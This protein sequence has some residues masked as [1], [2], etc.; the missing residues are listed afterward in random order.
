MVSSDALRA[1]VGSGE[2]DLEASADAF[3]V[4]HQVVAARSR[5]GLTVVVDTLGLDPDTRDRYRE[6]GRAAGLPCVAVVLDT[7][8]ATC[9]ERNSRRDRPVPAKVLAQ[10]L[11]RMPRV[12]EDVAGEGWDVVLHVDGSDPG[13]GPAAAGTGGPGTSGPE[14]A[15]PATAPGAASA[16]HRGPRTARPGVRQGLPELV[17]QVSRFPWGQDPVG[18]LRTVALA[19]DEAGFSGLALM[20]HLVQVPQVDRAWEPIPEPWVTLGLLAGLDTSLRLGT[21]VS[22]MTFRPAGVLAKAAATLDVLSGGRAFVGVGA[23]WWEREHL[24]FGVPFPPSSTRLDLLEDGIETMRALWASGTRAYAGQRVSLPETTA[25]PRPVGPLPVVVGGGGERR[26]LRVAARLGDACNVSS[27]RATVRRKVEVLHRHCS[28]VGRDPAE[29]AVTVLDVPV[30][31]RDREDTWRRVERLRGRT[32]AAAYA[33]T[34][35][36]GEPASHVERY[37]Q[38]AREG[39]DTVFVALPDLASPDDLER[40]APVLRG[41]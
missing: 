10:Q 4:L 13:T 11:A 32:A 16:W 6:M 17:L 31:G 40:F 33:R 23:G 35:H 1:V 26:T 28:E 27:D 34:H 2:Y 5:R 36:A 39:V 3:A 21:L 37:R 19:A 22:P 25:Y 38:L 12:A 30:V 14:P 24:G 8:G 15:V 41:S 9:R 20:D 29:V 7:P 18:W